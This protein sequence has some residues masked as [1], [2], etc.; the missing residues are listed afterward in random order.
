MKKYLIIALFFVG[1]TR[2]N[3]TNEEQPVL[4]PAI[5]EAL[6]KNTIPEIKN[7][8]SL[9]T[10]EEKELL[11]KTKL[12]TIQK[13][14]DR[15]F[16]TDQKTI[17]KMLQN[18]LALNGYTKLIANPKI[19]EEFIGSNLEYFAKHFT[20][21]QLFLLVESPYFTFDF[22][23]FNS[24]KYLQTFIKAEALS[25]GDPDGDIGDAPKCTCIYSISCSGSSNNCEDKK[26]ECVK[27]PKCGLFGTSNCTGRCSY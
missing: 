17:I 26:D 6:E 16:T 5:I 4:S 8:V 22:S 9:L 27:Q 11:W 14:D 12:E 20:K 1:C 7:S 3:V 21:E 23:V 25:V 19:G 10:N 2:S 24:E 15:K 18:V 13:N